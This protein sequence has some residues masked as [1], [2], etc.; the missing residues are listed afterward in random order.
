MVA[1]Q[2]PIAARTLDVLGV[3][4]DLLEEGEALGRIEYLHDHP[5]PAY[6]SYVNPHTAK[7]AHGDR[8]FNRVLAEACLRLADGFGLR[9]V[10]LRQGIKVP[11]VLNG[12]DFNRALLV[13]AADRGWPVFLLGGR[14]GVAETAGSR[15]VEGISALQIAGTH[16]GYFSDDEEDAVLNQIRHSGASL[17]LLA[18]GQPR[19]ELW[20]AR[21]LKRTGVR[22]ASAVGGFLDFEAGVVRRAPAWMNR[23]GIEWAFRLGEEPLRLAPRYLIGIPRYLWLVASYQPRST[24]AELPVGPITAEAEAG[25]QAV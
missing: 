14:T 15:L 3:Q 5:F 20:L 7:L 4:V 8:E 6:V 19:Q 22:L 25:Y 23:A 17:L 11:A 21:N 24:F 1:P 10:G 9:V 13:R 12:S 16:H 2:P 18:L